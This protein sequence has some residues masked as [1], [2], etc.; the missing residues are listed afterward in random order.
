M[1]RSTPRMLLACLV[2]LAACVDSPP[3]PPPGGGGG[4]G[5]P[6]GTRR[7]ASARDG[8]PED[9]ATDADSEAP[10]PRGCARLDEAVALPFVVSEP[11]SARPLPFAPRYGY[12]AWWPRACGTP[13]S[14]RWLLLGLNQ[15]GCNPGS[16]VRFEAWFR[17]EQVG[18]TLSPGPLPLAF[19][20][21][22][23]VEFARDDGRGTVA[24]WCNGPD[25]LGE[26][27]LET[28]GTRPG[29]LVRFRLDAQ[30]PGC[31]ARPPEVPIRIQ[32][33]LEGTVPATFEASCTP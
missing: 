29:D 3:P 27:T 23:R 1:N 26:L 25:A 22:L 7:D 9:G 4:G 6:L 20:E 18:L 14:E 2:G 30:L 16:G 28:I 8:S 19:A 24:N 10:L 21:Y 13:P 31:G 11:E 17:A 32:G 5:G 12:V 15:D 33:R